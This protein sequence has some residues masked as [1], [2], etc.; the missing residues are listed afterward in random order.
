MFNNCDASTNGEQWFYH[1]IEKNIQ[2]I[3]DVG[4][5]DD[6]MF[7]SFS[8]E[9]HYF[10]PV[11]T[12]LDTLA[13]KENNNTK[14][15]FNAFGLG[16]NSS[17]IAYFPKYESFFNRVKSCKMDD[18]KNKMILKTKRA[19]SYMNENNI[20]HIDFVKIDTEGYELKVLE[21]FGDLLQNVNIIQF[22]YGGTY[23]DNEVKLVDLKNFLE[24]K[25]FHKFAYLTNE[26]VTLITDFSDHYQYCNIVCVNKKSTYCPY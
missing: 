1:L 5:R 9:V 8:G 16:H 19:D 6:S 15:F 13:K 24:S 22:E 14:A 26:G 18:N 11:K 3:F 25:G 17:E 20:Q 2:I 4:S 7:V 12:F 10:D 21:G 23:I